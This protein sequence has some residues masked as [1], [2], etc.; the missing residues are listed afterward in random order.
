MARSS[1]SSCATWRASVEVPRLGDGPLVQ[2]LLRAEPVEVA[3][4]RLV[5]PA[6]LAGRAVPE[7]DAL[8]LGEVDDLDRVARD[9]D[10]VARARGHATT[11]SR[12]AS[13]ESR[14]P[15]GVHTAGTSATPRA[16]A[17]AVASSSARLIAS[18]S[19]ACSTARGCI[20]HA[21][22]AMSTTSVSP[23]SAPPA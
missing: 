21:E 17:S 2:E 18:R 22:A 8:A 10:L 12:A 9:L 19:S 1:R 6:T 11:P 13:P 3:D 20:S 4:Q 16:T 15:S 7:E 23:R 5:H 14:R